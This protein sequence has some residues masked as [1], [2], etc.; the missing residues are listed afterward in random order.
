M[1][2]PPGVTAYR[3]ALILPIARKP[4]QIPEV[5]EFVMVAMGLFLVYLGLVFYNQFTYLHGVTRGEKIDGKTMSKDALLVID[6]QSSFPQADERLRV[7]SPSAYQF[8]QHV[9]TAID[10][11]NR[12]G[13]DIVYIAQVKEAGTLR[14]LF[15]PHIPVRGSKEAALSPNLHQHQPQIITKLRADAFSNPELRRH[16]DQ[17]QV[18]KLFITGMA[19]EVCVDFTIQGAI[20]RGYQVYVI[21]EGIFALLGE[22]SKEKRLR[23]YAALGAKIISGAE[24]PKYDSE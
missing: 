7:K 22:E 5:H 13:G 4:K 20:N 8:I 11:F 15:M 2:L 12:R 23:K 16:L 14:S 19:A 6:I 21:R 18:G 9:N 24:L 17:R 3:R 1:E 10:Y